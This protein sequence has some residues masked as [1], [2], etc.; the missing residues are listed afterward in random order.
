MH[1]FYKTIKDLKKQVKSHL[2][3]DFVNEA[4]VQ[5]NTLD[6]EVFSKVKYNQMRLTH[7]INEEA[8]VLDEGNM[9]KLKHEV[10]SILKK[11]PICLLTT[12]KQTEL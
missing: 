4:V 11:F 2:Y 9:K 6:R 10:S 7:I 8:P 3:C 1:N 12:Q 5:Y